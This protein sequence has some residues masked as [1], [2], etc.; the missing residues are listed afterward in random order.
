MILEKLISPG[1]IVCDGHA[2]SKKHCLEILSELLAIPNPDIANE[3]IFTKL[4][5]RE[6]LG[7]TSMGKGIAFPHCRVPGLHSSCGALLTLSEPVDFDS[8]DDVLV[9]LIFGLIL[10]VEV[11]ETD[12]NYIDAITS[13]LT[14]DSLMARLRSARSSNE[15]YE[16]MMSGELPATNKLR[17][18]Q[19]L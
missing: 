7:S 10:P 8:P 13:L 12:E 14:S 18:V 16:F 4:V 6:R 17:S 5:E 19:N 11:S 15:L 9:D 2:R 1:S 3:E